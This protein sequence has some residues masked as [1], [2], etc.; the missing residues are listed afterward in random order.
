[1]APTGTETKRQGPET[2]AAGADESAEG[3]DGADAEERDRAV[4]DGGQEAGLIERLY[5]RLAPLRAE[6]HGHLSLVPGQ[7]YRFAADVIAVPI[8]LVEFGMAAKHYPILFSDDD[9]PTPFA[10]TG[11]RNGRNLF[12]DDQGR[13]RARAYVPAL[14]RRYPFLL[15]RRPDTDQ[16]ALCIDEEA[17]LLGEG[18]DRP[19][20]AE[21]EPTETVNE[22]LRF[23]ESFLKHARI[24]AAFSRALAER[25]LLVANHADFRFADGKAAE[26]TGFRVVDEERFGAL[27]DEVFLDWRRKGWLT[28]VYAHLISATNWRA[29]VALAS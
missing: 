27:A 11:I 24:T 18:G 1:M 26:L 29:L 21:G 4:A 15:V 10:L 7:G 2:A 9:P 19:L 17:P 23:C 13:W 22:A 25:D 16:A 14:L 12:V 6:R 3:Q 8:N 5:T 20:F 28:G